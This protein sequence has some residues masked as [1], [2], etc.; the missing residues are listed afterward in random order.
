MVYGGLTKMKRDMELVRKLLLHIEQE[1]T[2]QPLD[3]RH[4]EIDGYSKEHIAY[5]LK[6]MDDGGLIDVQNSTVMVGNIHRFVIDGITW[7][8]HEFLD[9][10][11]NDGVWSHTKESLK[12]VGSASFEVVKSIAVAYIGSKSSERSGRQFLHCLRKGG[13][14]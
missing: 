12:P 3:S 14:L 8:G 10:V 13:P 1:Y 4:I 6:I 2:Y 5:H 11:R 9:S 7:N